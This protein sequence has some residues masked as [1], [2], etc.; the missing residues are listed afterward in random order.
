M[1]RLRLALLIMIPPLIGACGERDP[2]LLDRELFGRLIAARSAH[3]VS[4]EP[5]KLGRTDRRAPN[6]D[7]FRLVRGPMFTSETGSNLR[8]YLFPVGDWRDI[9]PR[10][11]ECP[12]VGGI[13]FRDQ[14]LNVDLLV[15]PECGR[16][17]LVSEGRFVGVSE[18]GR[19]AEILTAIHTECLSLASEAASN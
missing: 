15:S 8:G 4:V 6:L 9:A 14:R 11:S 3:W 17:F 5:Q 10:D 2:V 19:W 7:D 1:D 16:I 12:I 18:A 13:Q